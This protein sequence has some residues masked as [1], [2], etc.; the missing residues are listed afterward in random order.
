MAGDNTV[1]NVTQEDMKMAA[2][3]V[4]PLSNTDQKSFARFEI[5][6]GVT[7]SICCGYE[8]ASLS[9]SDVDSLCRH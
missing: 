3:I 4:M 7:Y 2:M 6:S 1:W 5:L 9:I 8:G